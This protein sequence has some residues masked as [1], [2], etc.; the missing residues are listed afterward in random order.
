MIEILPSAEGRIRPIPLGF[1]DL[2]LTRGQPRTGD[3]IPGVN[4]E[5]C[6][7]K[8]GWQIVGLVIGS[9]QDAVKCGDLFRGPRDRFG[10][11]PLRMFT[12][13]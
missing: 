12:G 7:V 11:R 13:W 3:G 4:H 8:Q 5:I 1:H 2:P 9:D 6:M 10:S